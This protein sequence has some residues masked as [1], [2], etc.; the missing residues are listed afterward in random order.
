MTG[1]T[2][3]ILRSFAPITANIS[4]LEQGLSVS[5]VEAQLNNLQIAPPPNMRAWVRAWDS[6]KKYI[7]QVGQMYAYFQGYVRSPA[8]VATESLSD[9]A[10]SV[11][12]SRLKDSSLEQMLGEFHTT[13]QSTG[14]KS[15]ESQ[16]HL[17]KFLRERLDEVRLVVFAMFFF[18]V[19]KTLFVGNQHC[20][21]RFVL[22]LLFEVVYDYI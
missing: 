4:G 9:F 21:A 22:K 14:S 11:T 19:E 13:V 8:G 6:V 18:P 20:L 1:P 2:E 3:H 5:Q 15:N 10:A 16:Q 12:Q 17:F 7:G